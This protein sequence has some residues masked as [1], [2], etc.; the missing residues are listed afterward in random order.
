MQ[1]YWLRH[2]NTL[3]IPNALVT[4]HQPTASI[5]ENEEGG[6]LAWAVTF[7]WWAVLLNFLLFPN[8]WATRSCA[9]VSGCV[10][11]YFFFF[12]L[13]PRFFF[14]FFRCDFLC[15]WWPPSVF[16]EMVSV[17]C[18]TCQRPCTSRAKWVHS[19]FPTDIEGDWI[20]NSKCTA[21]AWDHH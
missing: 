3:T 21:H 18:K 17:N 12:L 2:L 11:N 10:F 19:L 7:G 6:P 16:W 15:D 1:L 5:V 14:F 9:S 13:P 4:C 20:M 8:S